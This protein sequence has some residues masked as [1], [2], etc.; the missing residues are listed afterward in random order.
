MSA[1]PTNGTYRVLLG[2]A[3]YKAGQYAKA[4]EAYQKAIDLGVSS[5]SKRLAKAKS[6]L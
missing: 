2:D 5:A 4:A 1:R 6:K 3:Y